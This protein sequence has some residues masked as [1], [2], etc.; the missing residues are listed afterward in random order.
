[1]MQTVNTLQPFVG[2]ISAVE[3]DTQHRFLAG[4][5]A[6]NFEGVISN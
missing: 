3:V 6:H 5:N 2:E 4:V 1:M